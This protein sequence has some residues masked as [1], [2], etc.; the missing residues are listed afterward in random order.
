[1]TWADVPLLVWLAVAGLLIMWRTERAKAA[2]H[3]AEAEKYRKWYTD[4]IALFSREKAKVARMRNAMRKAWEGMAEADKEVGD[5][6][7]E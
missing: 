5:D 3:Q 2:Y 6:D 1:M 7:A 4:T